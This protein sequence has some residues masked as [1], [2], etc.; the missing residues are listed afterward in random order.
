M[1]PMWPAKP[2]LEEKAIE[3]LKQSQELSGKLHPITQRRIATLLRLMNSYYSNLI[4]GN[5]TH[6]L[7]LERAQKNDYSAEPRKRSL[8]LEGKAHIEVQE[9]FE[10]IVRATPDT[11]ICT[12]QFLSRMHRSFY[13]KLPEDFRM[14]RSTSGKILEVVP[15]EVRTTDVVVGKHYPPSHTSL[16]AFLRRF[17]EV[18]DSHQLGSVK[19]IIAAAA[20]HHRLAW[21]HPFLDGNGRVVRLFTHL[22][23]IQADMD[24]NGLWALSRG[25]ARRREDYYNALEAA[26]E[27]RYNDY[28][29]RG[30]LSQRCLDDFV[31]F[32]LDVAIDQVGY[33]SRLLEID[34]LLERLSQYVDILAARGA[35]DASAKYVLGEVL[36]RGELARGE[37]PRI[38]GKPDRTARRITQSLLKLELLTSESSLSPLRMNF[39]MK[40]V[41]YIFPA[42]FPSG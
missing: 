41:P 40:S 9:E 34:G 28:D 36:L 26:D 31:E 39:P 23:F 14:V 32:I 33:M 27:H 21:I 19:K 1:E 24:S 13:G 12:S 3:L 18:Y 38:T 11:N 17:E 35:L 29:G 25:L 10:A 15:G 22:Y 20:S 8:Q 4:E 7:D 16:P 30:N 2:A 42:L 37:I 6:P 5:I